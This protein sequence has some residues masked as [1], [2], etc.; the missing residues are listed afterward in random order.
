MFYSNVT[1]KKELQVK[2]MTYPQYKAQYYLRFGKDDGFR[3]IDLADL[4]PTIYEKAAKEAARRDCWPSCA[5]YLLVLAESG[6]DPANFET[7]ATN[8]YTL[9]F[10]FFFRPDRIDYKELWFGQLHD[11]SNMKAREMALTIMAEMVRE[12]QV[13]RALIGHH[14]VQKSCP[15]RIYH[16][17]V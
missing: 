7:Y 11:E 10:G 2:P 17:K 15:K 9:A 13:A 3:L 4:D 6:G 14:H 5:C 8:L 1:K 12:A 16:G